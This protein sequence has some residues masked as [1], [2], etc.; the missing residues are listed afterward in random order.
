MF[1]PQL[2]LH[3]SI[4]DPSLTGL[5]FLALGFGPLILPLLHMLFEILVA[6]CFHRGFFRCS[7]FPRPTSF[8][9]EVISLFL[10]PQVFVQ[11]LPWARHSV[12]HIQ[13]MKPG[14]RLL[15]Q[16]QGNGW[17]LKIKQIPMEL[18]LG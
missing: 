1:K 7:L 8:L 9:N 2:I 4:P 17:H 12:G 18:H 3:I 16:T 11:R 15:L 5:C 13:G 10:P 6:L 14:R